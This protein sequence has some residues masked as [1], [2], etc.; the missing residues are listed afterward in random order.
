MLRHIFRSVLPAVIL[1]ALF[2]GRTLADPAMETDQ[3]VGSVTLESPS[4][5]DA[6]APF[7]TIT[8]F[9]SFFR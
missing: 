7:S 9:R 4:L 8:I 5:F 3:N 2:A 6:P 1:T